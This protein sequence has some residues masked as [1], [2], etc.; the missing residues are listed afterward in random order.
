MSENRTTLTDNSQ[1]TARISESKSRKDDAQ[2][3][4]DA[5]RT[6]ND[7]QKQNV[8][9]RFPERHAEQRRKERRSQ[10]FT[11]HRKDLKTTGV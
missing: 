7:T 6:E 1:S 8:N 5:S 2:G 9:K 10:N 3:T 4:N 11:D